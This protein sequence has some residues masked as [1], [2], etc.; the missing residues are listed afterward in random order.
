MASGDISHTPNVEIQYSSI[1]TLVDVDY[2]GHIVDPQKALKTLGGIPG[3]TK[4]SF[5]FLVSGNA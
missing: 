1:D 5:T 2:P 4:V 3:L